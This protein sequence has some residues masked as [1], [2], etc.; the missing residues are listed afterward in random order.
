MLQEIFLA[1]NDGLS[2]KIKHRLKQDYFLWAFK[3]RLFF[4]WRQKKFRFSTLW[5]RKFTSAKSNSGR[6]LIWRWIILFQNFL[7][8]SSYSNQNRKIYLLN[9]FFFR[10][11]FFWRDLFLSQ[12]FFSFQNDSKTLVLKTTS[13]LLILFVKLKIKK[14]KLKKIL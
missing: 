1:R 11:K 5:S 14:K 2:I 9:F 4:P 13:F 10:K 3:Q 12:Y 8:L 6:N 7:L